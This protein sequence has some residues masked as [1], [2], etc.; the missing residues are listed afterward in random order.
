MLKPSREETIKKL[1]STYRSFTP[2]DTLVRPPK[3]FAVISITDPS[4]K[5]VNQWNNKDY[6]NYF[7]IQYKKSFN[8]D[9]KISYESDTKIINQ[10]SMFLKSLG[11][12]PS[13]HSKLFIDW[14]FEN[15]DMIMKRK[16][17]FTLNNCKDFMNEYLQTALINIK[18]ENEQIDFDYLKDLNALFNDK[19]M[20]IALKRYGIVIVS[21]YLQ[22]HKNFS[23]DKLIDNINKLNLEAL[24]Y[25]KIARTTIMRS[26]YNDDMAM[27]NWRDLFEQFKFNDCNWWRDK[28]YSGIPHK[29]YKNLVKQ[30]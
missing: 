12:N 8:L 6:A 30:Q 16:Q 4:D 17:Y 26:P 9:Y 20:L 15:K 7:A 22:N 5:S 14:C 18:Q 28:D 11:I 3:E 23:I 13:T 24:D 21:T 27:R 25:E 29:D 10:I 1:I 2:G 19:K